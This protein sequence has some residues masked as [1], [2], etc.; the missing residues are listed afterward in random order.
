MMIPRGLYEA[1]ASNLIRRQ[2]QLLAP[3]IECCD[4]GEAFLSL[5]GTTK[6]FLQAKCFQPIQRDIFR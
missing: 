4:L 1:S 3:G 6:S 5:K 2:V